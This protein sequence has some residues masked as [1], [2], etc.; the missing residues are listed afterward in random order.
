VPEGPFRVRLWGKTSL[1]NYD[2]IICSFEDKIDNSF[3][4]T[5]ANVIRF[6]KSREK[7]LTYKIE[8]HDGEEVFCTIEDGEI[9]SSYRDEFEEVES[10]EESFLGKEILFEEVRV[11]DLIEVTK[12][13]VLISGT[14]RVKCIS[15]E[16][17]TALSV[18]G[19]WASTTSDLIFTLDYGWTYVLKERTYAE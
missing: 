11:G 14:V 8:S 9:V 18:E 2:G 7:G 17:I 16:K 13:S 15:P 1:D 10:E 12:S 5:E 6:A 4:T 19:A 3:S